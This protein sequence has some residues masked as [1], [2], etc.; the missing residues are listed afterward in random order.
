MMLS[1]KAYNTWRECSIIALLGFFVFYAV[2]RLLILKGVE[3]WDAHGFAV[4]VMLAFQVAGVAWRLHKHGYLD[5]L[6][7]V[8]EDD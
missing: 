2:L 1:D 8:M 5:R 4:F 7:A 6:S 3:S